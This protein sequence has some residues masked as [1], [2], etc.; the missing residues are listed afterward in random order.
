MYNTGS[1][2]SLGVV[3]VSHVYIVSHDVPATSRVGGSMYFSPVSILY[4]IL[5]TRTLLMHIT[6]EV[7]CMCL[8]FGS[9]RP[10]LSVPTR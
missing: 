9:F 1:S 4:K 2:P 10:R 7:L 6:L 3:F 5:V 8:L